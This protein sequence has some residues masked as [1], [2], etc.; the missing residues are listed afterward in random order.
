M[1]SLCKH[2]E[3]EILNRKRSGT[4]MSPGAVPDADEVRRTTAFVGRARPLDG[5]TGDRAVVGSA[6]G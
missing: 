5:A 2:Y 6:D 1:P 3:D 4:G